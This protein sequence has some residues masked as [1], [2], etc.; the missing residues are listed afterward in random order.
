MSR[1]KFITNELGEKKKFE[2]SE[3]TKKGFT[4]HS[5]LQGLWGESVSLPVYFPKKKY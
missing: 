1:K 3:P 4:P 5:K 2:K